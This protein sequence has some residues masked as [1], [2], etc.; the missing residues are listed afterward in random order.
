MTV[1]SF[2]VGARTE[3]AQVPYAVSGSPVTGFDVTAWATSAE[4]SVD[5]G[6]QV[7]PLSVLV[8]TVS[9]GLLSAISVVAFAQIVG[10]A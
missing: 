4:T 9:F 3:Q 2:L 8:L 7:E 1:A 6:G 5:V 10:W